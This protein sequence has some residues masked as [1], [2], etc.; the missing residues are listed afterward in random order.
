LQQ[1]GTGKLLLLILSLLKTLYK[2]H[3]GHTP[4]LVIL[5][6]TRE[7]VV[8]CGGSRKLTKYMSVRT[9]GISWR[10]KHQHTKKTTVYTGCDILVGTPGRIMDLIDNVVCFE[11]NKAS[12]MSST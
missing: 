3:P 11:E 2:S 8:R 9:V 5:V 10:R 4:K 7:L 1:T 6:P 12:Y